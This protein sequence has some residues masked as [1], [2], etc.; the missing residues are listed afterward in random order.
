VIQPKEPIAAFVHLL[1]PPVGSFVAYS[2]EL[3]PVTQSVAEAQEI[4]FKYVAPSSSVGVHVDAAPAGLVEVKT[5][6]PATS[7][8][9]QNELDGQD[10]DRRP[11]LPAMRSLTC[12]TPD[13]GAVLVM[14]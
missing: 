6:P 5:F 4:A 7:V 11:G 13:A 8:A 2:F 10:T 14:T 1:A 12:H 9:A 3:P